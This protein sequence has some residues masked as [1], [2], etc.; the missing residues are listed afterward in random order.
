MTAM[1]RMLYVLQSWTMR[2]LT[3]RLTHQ[4]VTTTQLAALRLVPGN[5]ATS[6]MDN[7]PPRPDL[8]VSQPSQP[9]KFVN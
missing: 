9:A 7:I 5:S 2:G 4:A 6:S 3:R 1:S 8:S